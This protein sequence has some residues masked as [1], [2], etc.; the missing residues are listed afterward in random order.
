MCGITGFTGKT[1]ALPFL[2]QGLERLEYRGYDS[3]GITLVKDKDL[4]TFK[5]KGKLK[6]L[7]EAIPEEKCLEQTGIGHTRWATH[8]VP[9]QLNAH[10]HTNTDNTISLVHNGIIEN[11]AELKER[12]LKDGY[13]FQ[14]E[15][16]SEVVV[17]LL[18]QNYKKHQGNM[19]DALLETVQKLEGSFA[20]CIVSV[21]EP[22]RVYVA[23]KESP[24]VLGKDENGTFCASDAAA[25][26]AYTKDI[27]VLED[28]QIAIL[29]GKNISLFD[30]QNHELEQKW[31]HVPYDVQAAQKG[32]FDSYMRKEI[33]E[34]PH[35]VK[36]T[37]R[38]RINA[39]G[40]VM[41]EIDDLKIDWD[42][43]SRVYFVA[44]GTAYHACFY[45][46]QL[47]QKSL[48]V[49]VGVEPASEFRYQEPI[50]DANTI[51]IFVSQS[52]ET[53]DTLAALKLA[54][55][56][57]AYIIAITNVLGSS[58]SRYAD[59]TIY[60]CAGPEISV[61]STKAYTTQLVLLTCLDIKLADCMHAPM[62]D[63]KIILQDLKRLPSI[64]EETLAME[65][66]MEELAQLLENQHDAYFI[67][68]QMD[69]PTALEGALKLKEISYVHAD[70]Y[71]AGELKH[72]PIAL[73]EK[74]TVVV[75]LA[76][77]EDI[78]QKT[79]SNMEETVA[80]GACVIVLTTQDIPVKGFEHVIRIPNV[81]PELANVPCAVLLQEFAY[82]TAK[83]KGR[84]IDQPRNLAKSV[85]VE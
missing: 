57:N 70:A 60:T 76:T 47:L 71:Y 59:T 31:I 23:K 64:I 32:G 49:H 36:E 42:H 66:K 39:K 29:D 38:G 27:L 78:A 24:M 55:A 63:K 73:I 7:K 48:N 58:I 6:D 8:G 19:K 61:A 40:V 43:V 54:K 17:H 81:T 80:R 22:D 37:L 44:C 1:K 3:A 62:K 28:G 21:F 50:I 75:T 4:Y 79:F 9:S 51:C 2:L 34:Q 56:H 74:D 41:P 69:Y 82:Y 5:A 15:T 14:S 83:L 46:K 11:Y 12:L 53:A 13:V 77:Q 26:I 10:P 84:D 35:A 85:T 30:F 25:L 16:D 20:L 18:D 65:P 45:A 33:H 72:G 68:R 52:G 67:G